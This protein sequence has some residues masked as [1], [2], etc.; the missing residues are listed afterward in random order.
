MTF[1]RRGNCQN[2]AA[3]VANFRQT[4]AEKRVAST[5]VCDS[6]FAGSSN[7]ENGVFVSHKLFSAILIAFYTNSI[8]PASHGGTTVTVTAAAYYQTAGSAGATDTA[9]T[10]GNP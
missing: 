6:G 1:L 2:I 9:A 4:I 10:G 8:S 3:S 5:W 7:Q